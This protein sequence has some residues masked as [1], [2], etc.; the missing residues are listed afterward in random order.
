MKYVFKFFKYSIFLL[1]LFALVFL[2]YRAVAV[3]RFIG[4][5]PRAASGGEIEKRQTEFA[6]ENYGFPVGA[7]YEI[8]ESFKC[9]A[10]NR[11]LK[12]ALDEG[13]LKASAFPKSDSTFHEWKKY[14]ELEG[15]QARVFDFALGVQPGK[16]IL[17]KEDLESGGFLAL[18]Y[19][20]EIRD[21]EPC[22]ALVYLFKH[23]NFYV[24]ERK[25]N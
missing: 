20:A 18:C 9:G 8:A 22:H 13:A 21:G 5:L 14:S 24:L 10:G 19:S 3:Y 25:K 6:L 7:K 12:I 2:A 11:L 15:W 16:K 4:G 1:G 23:P 17:S